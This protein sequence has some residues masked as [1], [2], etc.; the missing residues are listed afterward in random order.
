MTKENI[1]TL[2]QISYLDDFKCAADKC[3]DTCCAKWVINT[4]VENKEFYDRESSEI[5]KDVEP[6]SDGAFQMKRQDNDNCIQLQDGMCRV[7]KEFGEN[8]LPDVCYTFPRSYKMIDKE[9]YMTSNLA[10]P[11]SLKVALYNNKR[12]DFTKWSDITQTRRKTGLFDSRSDKLSDFSDQEILEISSKIACMVD[13]PSCSADESMARLLLLADAADYDKNFNWSDID[14]EIKITTKKNILQI[15]KDNPESVNMRNEMISILEVAFNDV[16]RDTPR[17]VEVLDIIKSK[18]G[19]HN[20]DEDTLFG[21]YEKI[22]DN[23]EGVKSDYDYILKNYIKAQ[24]SYI[25]FPLNTSFS[26]QYNSIACIFLEYLLVRL[27]LSCALYGAEKE[28]DQKDVIDVIQPVAKRFFVKDSHT[29]YNFC[30]NK[31]WDN[32]KKAI[33]TIINL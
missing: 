19:D 29:I 15:A 22:Y 2:K 4:T 30:K 8:Y 12:S 7:Q 14:N 32:C 33:T 13:D 5:A 24:L 31:G 3:P 6:H 23:W 16:Y 10:C 28:L 25:I 20:T 18:I 21:N 1:T 27:S 26:N 11:E 9:V 17:Y